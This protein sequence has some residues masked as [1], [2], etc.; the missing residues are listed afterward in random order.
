MADAMTVD[1]L[2]RFLVSRGHEVDLACFVEDA[3]ADQALR[4]GLGDVCRRI[5]TVTLPKWRSY[6]ASA[7]TLPGA[8]PLQVQYYR[9]DQLRA[10]ITSLVKS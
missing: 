4:E 7:L 5:E 10:R 6:L 3:A 2:L 1:R 8:L 9:S